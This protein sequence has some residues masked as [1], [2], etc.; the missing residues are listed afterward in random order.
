MFYGKKDPSVQELVSAV[1]VLRRGAK[2]RLNYLS[3]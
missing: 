2:V 1:V 3:N